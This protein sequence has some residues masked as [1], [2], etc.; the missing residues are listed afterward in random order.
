M[1]NDK[2]EQDHSEFRPKDAIDVLFGGA[3]PNPQRIGC[4][5]EDVLRAAARKALEMDHAVYG[6]LATCSPC[7]CEF[8]GYQQRDRRRSWLRAALAT[9][10]TV[11]LAFSA[12]PYVGRSLGIGPWTTLTQ[13]IILDYRSES[14]SRSETGDPARLPKILPRMKIA[15]TILAPTGSEPGQYEFRL[16]DGSGHVRFGQTARGEMENYAVRAKVLL[17][18]RSVSRGSYSLEIR[19]VGEDW[20]RHPVEIR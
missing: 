17:D 11:A 10:A 19:R 8:R 1:V 16:V 4:P 12:G 14:T 15:A 6:H 5:G 13:A 3:S 9:A 7:Y 18:L 2:R 20:D